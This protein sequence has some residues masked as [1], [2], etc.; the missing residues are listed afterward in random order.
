M[1]GPRFA[2]AFS[3]LFLAS[4][5]I[6]SREQLDPLRFFEGRTETQGMVK[7]MMRKAYRSHG[8]GHGRIG[9]DGSLT[10]VQ[11]VYDEGKPPHERHWKVRRAGPGRFIG[12]MSQAVGPVI[13][14][15][16]GERYRFRFKMKGNLRAEQWLTPQEDGR[17]A[18]NSLK[19]RRLGLVVA[20][21]TGSIRKV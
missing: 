7:V 8:V 4:P 12:S 6:S 9:P 20:T 17:S 13:I 15:K 16:I 14:D 19:V 18:R 10:L 5:A 2:V 11:K 3:A 21:T 1:D